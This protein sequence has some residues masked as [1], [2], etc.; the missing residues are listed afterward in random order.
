[1]TL[2]EQLQQQDTAEEFVSRL[3]TGPLLAVNVIVLG[4]LL[5]LGWQWF[6]VPLGVS[7]ISVPQAYGIAL[8]LRIIMP[9]IRDSSKKTWKSHVS[10]CFETI[11][12]QL[13]IFLAMAVCAWLM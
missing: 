3:A 8:L 2:Q 1:M 10:S 12:F 9:T 11:C 5:K 13:I 7:Q 6:V 4:L